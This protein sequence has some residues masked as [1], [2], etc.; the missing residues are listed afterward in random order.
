MKIFNKKSQS[1]KEGLAFIY[2]AIYALFLVA[3]TIF[4]IKIVVVTSIPTGEIEVNLFANRIYNSEAIMYK[5]ADTGRVYP[6][7]IDIGKFQDAADKGGEKLF[8]IEQ[9]I[10]YLPNNRLAA[11]IIASYKEILAEGVEG[12]GQRVEKAIYINK[13]LYELLEAPSRAGLS[14]PGSGKIYQRKTPAYVLENGQQ[15]AGNLEITIIRQND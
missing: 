12:P 8:I 1:L 10:N 5:D 3:L 2:K 13:R 9:D 15:T 14:G 4:L 6:G 7:I 11:K